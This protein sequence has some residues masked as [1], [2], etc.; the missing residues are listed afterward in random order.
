MARSLVK[1]LYQHTC[2]ERERLLQQREEEEEKV[3]KK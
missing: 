3:N 2:L 1:L